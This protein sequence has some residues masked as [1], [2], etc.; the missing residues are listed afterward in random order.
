MTITRLDSN[1]IEGTIP[2][3]DAGSVD[4]VVTNRGGQRATLANYFTYFGN[5][6]APRINR[7]SLDSGSTEGGEPLV[8]SGHD[9]FPGTTLTIGGVLIRGR[10]GSEAEGWS[11]SFIEVTTPAHAVGRVDIVVTNP[12]GQ[13]DS[14]PGGYEYV[15]PESLDFNGN[16]AVRGGEYGELEDLHFRIQDDIVVGVSCDGK[17][18]TYSTLPS[19]E[20]GAFTVPL[21]GRLGKRPDRWPRCC[22]RHDGRAGCSR[23]GAWTASKY[24]STPTSLN[25]ALNLGFPK[26]RH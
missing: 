21:R 18:L 7:V 3:H 24:E 8:V 2:S 11:G 13:F 9:F 12:D 17:E 25:A 20:R 16:W 22:D 15:P 5:I 4:I 23:S 14:L 26:R 6:A 19:V 10:V 1:Q